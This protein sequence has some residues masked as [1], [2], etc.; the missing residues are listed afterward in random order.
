MMAVS[1]AF[2]KRLFPALL[3]LVS[4]PFLLRA[5]PGSS[6]QPNA[7]AQ[8]DSLQAMIAH[9]ESQEKAKRQEIDRAL[10]SKGLQKVGKTPQGAPMELMDLGA[11]GSPLYYTTLMDPISHPAGGQ[12]L[13]PQSLLDLG[14]N[15]QGMEVGIWD[16]GL[17]LDSHQEFGGRAIPSD[18]S[19]EVSLHATLVTGNLISSGVQTAAR[20]VAHGAVAKTHDWARDKIEVAQ[21]AAQGM[22]L[23]NHSY[24]ILPDRVPDWYFGAYIQVSR[25]WD[26]IMYHAPYYLMVAAAGNAQRSGENAAPNHGAAGEGY[27]MLLGF[28]TAKNGLTVA[29][30]TAQV[31]ASGGWATA[32]VAPY[33]SFGPT[34][35]G[36][37]KPDLAG[38]GS[39]I[40][41]TSSRSNS[42]YQVSAGTS[43]AAP[44]VTG[45]LLLLQ[46]LQLETVGNPLRAASLKGLVLHSAEDVGDPGP[47]Y[48][49][50]WGTINAPKATELLQHRGH[51]SLLTE[52]RLTQG[53]I[54]TLEVEARGEGPLVVSLSWTDPDGHAV[55]QGELNGDRPALVNDLDIRI[56]QAGKEFFPW[57]LDP[58][59]AQAPATQGDN[60]V[61][62][63]ER[64]EIPNAS[65]RYTIT[66][67]HKGTLQNGLQDFSL[68]VSGAR[69]SDC[70]LEPPIGLGLVGSS[71][72]GAQLVWEAQ[73]ETLFELQ[74]RA[75][76]DG[77]WTSVLLWEPGFELQ[78]LEFAQVYEL[79]LR[80]ICSENAL[81][82][83]SPTLEFEFR[84][85]DTRPMEPGPLGHSAL[86]SLN[87]FPNPTVD[88]LNLDVLPLG[89]ARYSIVAT[90]GVV[91]QKGKLEGSIPVS[92]LADGLYV[93]VVQE[94]SG[95]RSAKFYKGG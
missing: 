59:R 19:R 12:A 78:E 39:E 46:Q 25:D 54:H 9:W 35:D 51:S 33:S 14:L 45:I 75:K 7:V 69:F 2:R 49:M 74:Y 48:R 32:Q 13:V 21:A 91:V 4:G 71:A 17:A 86:L 52:E 70:A 36:R 82:E 1:N 8:V 77:A 10:V 79:R 63:Y 83:F 81:S 72:A 65:G 16:A 66:I 3:L 24:G 90:S 28:T 94:L 57:R 15:G 23:S 76:G 27:D 44:G 61:D 31:G 11:D 56:A 38:D 87:L 26:K 84:G 64:I 58:A 50:G 53:G 85:Q 5:Q 40:L 68:I 93:L 29:A 95:T 30:A 20:G 41:S 18:G 67:S 34:D 6:Q 55:N 73:G 88:Y 47:D 22:L 80:A 43:M 37:I 60:R 62:P 92:A 42:S 89:P